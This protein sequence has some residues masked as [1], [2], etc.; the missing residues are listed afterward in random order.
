MKENTLLKL[1]NLPYFTTIELKS[2]TSEE[3]NTLKKSINRFL[4]KKLLIQL[5][6]GTYVTTEYIN[7][8]KNDEKIQYYEFIASTLR[9]PSYLSLEYVL[10]KYDILTESSYIQTSITT[11]NT[12]AYENDLGTF[13]YNSIKKELFDGYETK[14]FRDKPYYIA[15]LPKALFDYIYFRIDLIN[16]DLNI[17]LIEELRIKTEILNKKDWMEIEKYGKRS[18]NKKIIKI[19]ENLKKYAPH[20]K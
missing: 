5:K 4:S 3:E 13:K 15:T 14:Y 20:Y 1:N 9:T 8:L 19:I 10:T 2:I 18:K 16:I 6:K 17:N 12:I 11:K 7:N